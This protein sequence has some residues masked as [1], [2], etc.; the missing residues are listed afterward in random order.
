[1]F[2]LSIVQSLNNLAFLW[3]D[4][5]LTLSYRTIFGPSVSP[6]S[7]SFLIKFL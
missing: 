5:F 3:N 1:M 7:F 6:T 2:G 4:P